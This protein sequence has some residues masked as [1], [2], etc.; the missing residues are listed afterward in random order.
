M[1]GLWLR[2]KGAQISRKVVVLVAYA[3][4]ADGRRELLDFCQTSG[5]SEAECSHFLHSLHQRGLRGRHLQVVTTDG[6]PGLLAAVDLVYPLASRQRCWVHKPRNV[7]N[8]LRARHREACLSEARAIYQADP[9]QEAIRC[10]RPRQCH[11]KPVGPQAVACLAQDIEALLVC[12]ALPPEHR[13]RIR[14]TNPLERAFR[15]VRRRTKLMSCF[16]N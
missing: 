1:D 15:E 5:E 9:R 4:T 13:K 14:T 12:F 8:K 10:F 16:N 7:S 3:I 2:C 11:W 6:A